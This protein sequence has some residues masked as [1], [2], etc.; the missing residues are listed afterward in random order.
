MVCTAVQLM[1]PT[2]LHALS[3]AEARAVR[4]KIEAVEAEEGVG[5]N[6]L[7]TNAHVTRDWFYELAVSE[8]LLGIVRDLIGPD[9]M[10]WKSQLWIKESGSGSHVGWHQDAR[11][12][13][14]LPVG[15]CV[16]VWL[17]LSDVGD[18]NGPM[19][20]LRH[21][22]NKVWPTHETY[23]ATNLLTRGQD[24]DWSPS[25]C[26]DSWNV[27]PLADSQRSRRGRSRPIARRHG[28]PLCRP[29]QYSPPGSRTRRRA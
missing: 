15:D 14:L 5:G 24:I 16:N 6:G 12:W 21:S 18:E 23:Q 2:P 19:Q 27:A 8:P 25:T 3:S 17:A 29:I 26:A 22:H 7:F 10:I 1:I 11:Y 9:V 4:R 13:G 20:F 28:P